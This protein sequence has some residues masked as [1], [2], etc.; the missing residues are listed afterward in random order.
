MGAGGVVAGSTRV[1]SPNDSAITGVVGGTGPDPCG[2]VGVKEGALRLGFA[3]ISSEKPINV[4][5]M[6]E[7]G[8]SIWDLAEKA[9][10]EVDKWPE[11]KRRAAD[12]ALVTRPAPEPGQTPPGPSRAVKK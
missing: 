6:S 12:M 2:Q 9:Q 3:V 7:R 5:A 4:A 10:A 8:R 1:A 11:W